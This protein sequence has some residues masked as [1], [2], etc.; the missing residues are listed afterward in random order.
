MGQGA[1]ES[2]LRVQAQLPRNTDRETSRGPRVLLGPVPTVR[3]S[4]FCTRAA[5][6]LLTPPRDNMTRS[7]VS[8]VPLPWLLL[9]LCP[10]LP[11][12]TASSV[13]PSQQILT[14]RLG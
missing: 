11:H 10:Q 12:C 3:W 1:G 14:L 4:G 2:G 6:I 7:V 8:P 5:L 13:A 9:H